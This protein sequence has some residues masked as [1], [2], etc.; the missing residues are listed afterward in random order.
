[1]ADTDREVTKEELEALAAKLGPAVDS[2][3]AGEREIF[4]LILE[5]AGAAGD[6]VSGFGFS[7]KIK[8]ES[9]SAGWESPL[10]GGLAAAAGMMA[11]PKKFDA[12]K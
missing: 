8:M 2:L 10:A 12:G 4:E 5:R 3:S 9:G 6:E 11:A 1:M 7:Y